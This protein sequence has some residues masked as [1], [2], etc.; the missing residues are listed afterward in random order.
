MSECKYC[1]NK[2][3]EPIASHNDV[4]IFMDESGLCSVFD[5]DEYNRRCLI[6]FKVDYCPKCGKKFD[7]EITSNIDEVRST[8]TRHFKLKVLSVHESYRDFELEME[9]FDYDEICISIITYTNPS[10]TNYIKDKIARYT[11]AFISDVCKYIENT[12]MFYRQNTYYRAL[13]RCGGHAS[14]KTLD[15]MFNI[16]MDDY[17]T[18]N[19][20][21]ITNNLLQYIGYN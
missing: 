20:I 8:I 17:C 15:I 21:D 4:R 18:K 6:D 14:H 16:L 10:D 1:T 13:N 7:N 11:Y 9:P 2:C 19:K 3:T 5:G 12:T